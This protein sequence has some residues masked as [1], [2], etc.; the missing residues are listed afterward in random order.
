MLLNASVKN[1]LPQVV[2]SHRWHV[3]TCLMLCS[4]L[5]VSERNLLNSLAGLKRK[6]SSWLELMAVRLGF[7]QMAHRVEDGHDSYF[8]CYQIYDFCT[9]VKSN[10]YLK[11]FDIYHLDIF[12]ICTNC[13]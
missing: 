8:V 6:S 11:S 4:V 3:K 12:F 7:N 5:Q 9:Q 13:E 2:I 1:K 10:L